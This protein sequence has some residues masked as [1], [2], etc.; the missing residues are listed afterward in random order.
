MKDALERLDS[1]ALFFIAG[2]QDKAR[3]QYLENADRFAEE[4]ETA[5]GN[6]TE[7]DE[8]SIV[9]D[10][11]KNFSLYKRSIQNFISTDDGGTATKTAVYFSQLEPDFASLKNRLEDLLKVN[12]QAML[13]AN[14]RAISRSW[15]AE[16]SMAMLALLALIVA[17]VF[18]WR[19]T[20]Y[21]VEPITTLTEKAKLIGEGDFEQHIRINSKDEIGEL[22][23]EFNRMLVRLR[24][25]RQSEQWQLLLEKK[26]S[27]A[28]IDS[29]YEPV[30]VTDAQGHVIKINNSARDFFLHA[31]DNEA[32]DIDYSLSGFS[33]GEPILKAV[34]DTVAMQK[35][36]AQKGDAAIV[37]I[38]LGET[39]RS[40]RLRTT[41]VRD[42]DGRLIGA[43]TLLEDLTEI[44]EV[45]KLKSDF[46][47]LASGK[48]RA[49]LRALQL[50]LHA[51]IEGYTGDLNEQQKDMLTDARQQSERLKE[52]IDDLLE[53]SEIESGTRRL[54]IERLRPVELA[55]SAI[56]RF[57]AAADA[58]RVKLINQVATDLAWILADR[59][60]LRRIFDNLLS[61]AIRHSGHGGEVKLDAK[62]VVDRVMFSVCDSGEGIAETQLPILFNRFVQ[63]KKETC[64]GTGLGLA[65]VKRLV[66]AQ[67]GQVAVSS[68]LGEGTTFTFTLPIG[69]YSS[70]RR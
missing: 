49:P 18:A 35:P 24:D 16:V 48:L 43:V 42:S 17:W 61:N 69:G 32:G 4:F 7:P 56:E 60:A 13:A 58:R 1:S 26:K 55:R 34:R 9:T 36:V 45:D 70:A 53:L 23:A 29:I 27:D 64:G 57:Q 19:F 65:L 14:E 38:K 50:A 31:Q 41:P 6:I 11:G 68:R 3:A 30:I 10:I 40:Y 44:R 2:Q 62:E 54:S 8:D 67:G 47:T 52:I 59:E 5:A 33:A 15:E 21:V 25:L 51:V 22:A 20:N 28:V 12:Q 37:P 66:E 63:I 39:E 46:I